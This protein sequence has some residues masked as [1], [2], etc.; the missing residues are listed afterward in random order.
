MLLVAVTLLFCVKPLQKQQHIVTR[1]STLSHVVR[2][3]IGRRLLQAPES[4]PLPQG[5]TGSRA[6]ML[7][8]TF[9]EFIVPA[10][11]GFKG[12]L[13][14]LHAFRHGAPAAKFAYAGYSLKF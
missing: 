6:Q 7:T 9:A 12:E 11:G 10:R 1:H 2:F 8:S 5:L 14:Q 13:G 4:K 3:P